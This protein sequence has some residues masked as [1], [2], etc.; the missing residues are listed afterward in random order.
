[1]LTDA[2]EIRLI[3]FVCRALIAPDCGT[4]LG[5][6]KSNGICYYYNDTD[7]VDFHTAMHRCYQEKA[8]LASILNQEEQ[9][10][11]NTMVL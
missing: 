7:I 1:M 9:A 4:N 3:V 10:Y 8:R 5:W 2:V 11:I 6:R